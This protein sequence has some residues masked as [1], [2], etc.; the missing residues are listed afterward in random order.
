VNIALA[1]PPEELNPNWDESSFHATS[2]MYRVAEVRTSEPEALAQ[3]VEDV[4]SACE[5][6]VPPTPVT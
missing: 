5:I 4:E 2:G 3:Y 6:S 1:P